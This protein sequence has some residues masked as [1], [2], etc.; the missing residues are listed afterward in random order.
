MAPQNTREPRIGDTLHYVLH[1]GPQIGEHRPAIVTRTQEG[2]DLQ[3]FSSGNGKSG[4]KMPNVFW[5]YRVKRDDT[6]KEVGT[7]HWPEHERR[8]PV[9]GEA[10]A[11]FTTYG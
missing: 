10:E 5:R 1:A 3:V 9:L 8:G 7:W 2:T 4:D 11:G 6:G